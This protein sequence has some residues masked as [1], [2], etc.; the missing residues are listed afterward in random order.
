MSLAANA[1]AELPLAADSVPAA[2][3]GKPPANRTVTPNAD[4]VQQPEAR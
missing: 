3:R 1:V 4:A 2:N